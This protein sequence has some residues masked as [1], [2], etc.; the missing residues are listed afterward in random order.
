MWAIANI[1]K[2]YEDI[3]FDSLEPLIEMLGTIIVNETD[4]MVVIDAIWTTMALTR[5]KFANINLFIKE[6]IINGLIKA[7]V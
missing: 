3:R 7:L 5:S 1:C 2:G 6:N 4:E